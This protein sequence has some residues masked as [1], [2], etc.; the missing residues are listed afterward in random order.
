MVQA[1][2]LVTLHHLH[3]PSRRSIHRGIPILLA[4]GI[5]HASNTS[6]IS[7]T[8]EA[9]KRNDDAND[10]G[11]QQQQQHPRLFDVKQFTE[12]WKS[13][14]GFLDSQV[15]TTKT[16][17]PSPV[18]EDTA[19][20]SRI[21]TKSSI[22]KDSPG[23]Y[24][25]LF[26]VLKVLMN[27]T[28]SSSSG[29]DSNAKE[30]Q[31][32]ERNLQDVQS[33]LLGILTGRGRSSQ[34]AVEELVAKARNSS[35]Q[36][37]VADSVSLEELVSILR[38]VGEEIGKTFETH[39]GGRVLPPIYPTNL[40]YYLE[41]QDEIKNFS[42][43][44]RK[45]R[46]CKGINVEYVEELNSYARIAQMGYTDD[47]ESIIETLSETF[48]YEVIYC[49]MDSLPGQPSHFLAVKRNQSLWSPSLD[50]LLCVRGTKTIT[51]VITDLLADA[52]DYRGGK[53]HSGILQSGRFLA[54]KHMNT[55]QEF[56]KASGKKKIKLTLVGHS[57]GAGAASI[58]GMELHERDDFEVQVVGFG[59]P[60]LVSQELSQGAQGYITTVVDDND[61]V[62]RISLA[63]MMN[64]T[65]DIG[66][67][68]WVPKAKQDIEDLI[69]QVQIML[70]GF[71]TN[72]VKAR[73]LEMLNN[74]LLSTI[75]IPKATQERIQ[76]VLFPRK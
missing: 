2:F 17:S 4:G 57:L 19:S 74:N 13:V 75:V 56:L 45:H 27:E 6:T 12:Q 3:T 64:A 37:D 35:E 11:K 16:P 31:D 14:Q 40:Y 8:S 55:F 36:G 72:R 71:I 41:A 65:M 66:E 73:L 43:R 49:Q 10:D 9:E 70:P 7:S 52:V 21:G 44:R 15:Q 34:S 20:R 5:W 24:N 58:A 25:S 48:G 68:N 63:T 46:F 67:Y 53:A 61:C 39:L 18:T 38:S 42:W 29:N 23:S 30:T 76:P 1:R 33:S 22:E 32:A 62:P 50:M 60:A 28:D 51:D 54:G 69:D 26:G 59:C 47:M